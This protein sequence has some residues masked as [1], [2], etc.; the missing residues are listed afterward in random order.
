MLNLLKNEENATLEI[1]F[2]QKKVFESQTREDC[3]LKELHDLHISKLD[4]KSQFEKLNFFFNLK[5]KVMKIFYASIVLI[6]R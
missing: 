5:V 1:N 2:F 3:L 6:L 4:L